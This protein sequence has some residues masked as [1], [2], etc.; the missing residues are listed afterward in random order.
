MSKPCKRILL[1]FHWN[2]IVTCVLYNIKISFYN[3]FWIWISIRSTPCNWT[4]D[5]PIV[6]LLHLFFA[7]KKTRIFCK[8]SSYFLQGKLLFLALNFCN[9]LYL[10][11]V[12][13]FSPSEIIFTKDEH[14]FLRT[15]VTN[16]R[17][18]CFDI[19]AIPT[20]CTL[21]YQSTLNLYQKFALWTEIGS[22][23]ITIT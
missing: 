18:L 21:Y 9:L 2:Y 17:V 12:K 1:G 20:M 16:L 10:F 14:A 5:D 4:V 22:N 7:T 11:F 8:K 6:A 3:Q 19:C 15:L 23:V 13:L